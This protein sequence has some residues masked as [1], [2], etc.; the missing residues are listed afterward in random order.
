M[1]S[2]V[3]QELRESRSL[4]YTAMSMYQSPSKKDKSYMG[5]SYIATQNDKLVDA[6]SALTGLVNNMPESDKSFNLAKDG[7]IQ[8]MRT[9]RTAE[10]FVP[11]KT[12]STGI[13]PSISVLRMNSFSMRLTLIAITC[14]VLP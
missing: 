9:E 10:I 14:Y 3:F 6:L 7:I 12:T 5:I 2:I 11:A 13:L 8:K 4:A 1:N